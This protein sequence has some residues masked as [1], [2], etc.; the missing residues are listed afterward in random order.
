MV[1]RSNASGLRLPPRLSDEV[2]IVLFI[3]DSLTIKILTSS[4]AYV[5]HPPAFDRGPSSELAALSSTSAS[6][7]QPAEGD[8]VLPVATK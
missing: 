3:A 6:L 1:K 4:F 7:P 5:P 8:R 2:I